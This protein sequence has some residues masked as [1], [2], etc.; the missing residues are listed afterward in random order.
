MTANTPA[1]E[2]RAVKTRRDLKK[3]I[4]LPRKL[5][6]GLEGYVPPLDTEQVSLLDPKKSPVFKHSKIEYFLAYKNGKP[7]GRIAAIID[8]IAQDH[9]KDKNGS[10]GAFACLPEKDTV[11][12][13]LKA[14]EDWLKNEG[15]KEVHGPVTLTS[16]GES[17]LLV[18]GFKSEPMVAM[19]WNPPGLDKLVIDCGYKLFKE[20]L[21]YKL[22]LTPETKE[23]FKLPSGFEIGKGKL[24]N[25]EIQS[26]SKKDIVAQSEILRSLYNDAWE[27]KYNYVPLQ[28]YE[29]ESL[30][31]NV[32]PILKSEYYVQINCDGKPV[33]MALILPNIYDLNKGIGGNPTPWGWVK[34]G[35]RL[36]THKFTSGRVI[37]LGVSKTMR[38]TMLGSLLPALVIQELFNRREQTPFDWVELGWIQ[39]DDKGMRNLAE[40]LVD[41]P[42]KIHAL[43]KKAIQA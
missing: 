22:D 20:L 25:L 37:L 9:N 3:F 5:Y 1:I 32:K 6:K 42:Y 27:G 14:A 16:N 8:L 15:V 26:M 31:K 7:C 29:V 4:T 2:V 24:K 17:G 38:G 41:H 36:L 21:S 18:R 11:C 30:L 13:L 28:D 19:P 39:A 23:K 35:A 12:A 33:A 10:F 40:S 34:M 43:Y